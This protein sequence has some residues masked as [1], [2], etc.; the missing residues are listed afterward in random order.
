MFCPSC[1]A[2]YTIELKYCNR[3]GANLGSVKMPQSTPIVVSVTKPILILGILML[4]LTLGGFAIL[5]AGAIAL[6]PSVHG[7]DPLIAMIL[8]G[9][10][11]ILTINVFLARLCRVPMER[12]R[13]H[14]EVYPFV[15]NGSL[16]RS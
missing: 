11:T 15:T 8:V 7:S 12:V 6:S 13:K 14:Q 3:C 4:L 9:M 1:G 5:I 2:E 16:R 10:L